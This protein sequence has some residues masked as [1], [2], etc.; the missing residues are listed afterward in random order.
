[1]PDRAGVWNHQSSNG[2]QTVFTEGTSSC[3]L[4][5][6]SGIDCLEF[7]EDSQNM[8]QSS[9]LSPAF[10]RIAEVILVIHTLHSLKYRDR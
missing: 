3:G 6:G 9:V 1:M 2:I 4:R 7:E 8:E 5:V 10:M